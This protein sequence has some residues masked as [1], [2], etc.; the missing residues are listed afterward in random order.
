VD[1]TAHLAVV[2]PGGNNDPWTPP[3][4]LPALALEQAGA[5][6]ERISYG[7]PKPRGLGLDDSAEFNAAV[8]EQVAEMIDRH[9]PDRVTFVAKSRGTLFL[10]AMDGGALAC[11]VAAIWVTTPLVDLDYVRRGIVDK[12]WRSLLVAGSADPYHDPSIHSEIRAALGAEELIIDNAN[13]GL[14]V[15]R[16]ALA[17]AD[18][19]RQLAEASLVFAN[20]TG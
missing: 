4:L 15:E 3:V 6:V 11:Q 13:H 8:L 18:G 1:V 5:A 2:L 17:T 20:A 7:D 10:A 14:V 19:Y 16:D 9:D 12:S